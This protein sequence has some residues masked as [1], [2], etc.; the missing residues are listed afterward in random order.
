MRV[1]LR[2]LEG[3]RT[4]HNVTDYGAAK[5]LGVV[6]SAVQRWRKGGGMDDAVALRAADLLGLDEGGARR[7]VAELHAERATTPATRAFWTRLATAAVLVL[8][9]G[10]L[11]SGAPP[12]AL[13]IMSNRAR[14]PFR[15]LFNTL[16][17]PLL[18]PG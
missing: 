1:T 16:R 3:I 12:G 15:P 11:A 2:I 10:C 7:L 13:L 17:A 9:L 14:R 8:A 4:R 18:I 6:Y 5:L